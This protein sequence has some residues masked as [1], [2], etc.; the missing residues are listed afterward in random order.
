MPL[1][2]FEVYLDYILNK[3]KILPIISDPTDVDTDG[4]GYTDDVD[5]RPL[6]ANV[7]DLL[8]YNIGKLEKLAIDYLDDVIDSPVK[9][10]LS[11]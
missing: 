6:I 2:I 5:P 1:S 11:K 9:Y 3:T 8:A 4:D 10:N 7:N